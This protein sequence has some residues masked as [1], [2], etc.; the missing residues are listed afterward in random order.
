MDFLHFLSMQ[1]VQTEKGMG[2]RNEKEIWEV[3]PKRKGKKGRRGET[4]GRWV[5]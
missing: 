3:L 1:V 4:G 2:G 5:K